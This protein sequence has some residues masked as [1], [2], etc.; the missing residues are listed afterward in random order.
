MSIVL[1]LVFGVVLGLLGRAVFGRFANPIGLYAVVWTVSLVLF[2][3]RL[4]RYYDLEPETWLIILGSWCAYTLGAVSV[5]AARYAGGKPTA[6]VPLRSA[7][8]NFS[9]LSHDLK[10]MERL[11]WVLNVIALLVVLQ[12]WGVAVKK[13]GSV[14]NVILLGNIVYSERVSEGLP[15]TLPYLD[16]F[17]MTGTILGGVYTGLSRKFK[18]VTLVPLMALVCI[19][20]LNMGRLKILFGAVFYFGAYAITRQTFGVSIQE[21]GRG[22]LRRL[23]P[24]LVVI[25][26]VVGGAEFVRSV[27]G[28]IESLP[29]ATATLQK[30][31]GSSIITPS[32]YLYLTVDHGV[33]NQYLRRDEEHT[34]WGSNT[35]APVYRVLSKFGFDTNL[36][37]YQRFYFTPVGSNTGTYLRELHADFGLPGVFLVPFLLGC[38]IT[39]LWYRVT[40]SGSYIDIVLFVHGLL[41]VMLSFFIVVTRAGDWWI[42]LFVGLVVAHLFDRRRTQHDAA[43]T[44]SILN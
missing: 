42:S 7:R 32:V 33:L 6:L 40:R 35:F 39:A 19:D 17:A 18:I 8:T 27:R 2:E 22:L 12:H 37:V 25:A 15:G 23:V 38:G 44:E 30:I 29:A 9:D 26:L 3:A 5:A 11:L 13:F 43:A 31:R 36:P 28:S 16:A 21:R 14:F 20:V 4:I 10:L 24:I 1:V 41:A 34:P